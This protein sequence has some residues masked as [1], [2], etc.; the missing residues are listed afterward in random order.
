MKE[1]ILDTVK[2]KGRQVLLLKF[3]Y[4]SKLIALVKQL[5][6]ATW[7]NTHKSWYIAYSMDVLHEVKRVFTD[8]A[9][10]DAGVL[11]LK[12]AEIKNSSA[13]VNDRVLADEATDGIKKLKNWMQSR[14]Y[15]D[16]TVKTYCEALKSFLKFYNKK[17]LSEITNDDI[18]TFNN[19]FVLKY[20]LSASYQSQIV[21]AIKLFFKEI[22][23]AALNVDLVHRPK[24][25]N[26]LPKVLAEEE[27]ADI[28]NALDNIKHK[29]M[30]S[31]IYSAGLRRSELLKMQLDDIDSNRMQL[32]IR[33]S[34][35]GKDRIAPLSETVLQLLRQY[36]V[37]YKPKKYVFEG[38]KGLQYNERSLA[39]VLKKGCELAGIKKQVNLHMLRHSYATHLL[40]GGTDLRYIQTLLGHK[41]SKTTE[42]Y[43]HVSQKSINKIVSPLDKLNIKIRGN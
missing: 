42:I 34:K 18:I 17:A 40:E 38:Q 26:P 37:S 16:S 23:H 10:I 12:L 19:G 6:E 25:Y 39:L 35:G 22:Q 43:T 36:Y 20:K 5:P 3:P 24:K 30:L 11:K 27:V 13:S 31:L 7:S 33:Q 41:S 14:R 21:N 8:V 29:C 32:R 2:H 9:V 15:S 28:I 1:L 4:D